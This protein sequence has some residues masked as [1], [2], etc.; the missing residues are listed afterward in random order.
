MHG[1]VYCRLSR[2]SARK[3][4]LLGIARWLQRRM[5]W[6]SGHRDSVFASQGNLDDHGNG[7]GIDDGDPDTDDD[8]S[9]DDDDDDTSY[10]DAD[11]DTSY[12]DAD[13]DT[14]YDDAD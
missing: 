6:Y 5:M 3:S 8:T 9:Y 1:T 11:D 4:K 7:N 2:N 14:L 12:D 10:D 13:D